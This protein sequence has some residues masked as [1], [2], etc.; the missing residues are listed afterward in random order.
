[1]VSRC[2]RLRSQQS[3]NWFSNVWLGSSFEKCFWAKY[4]R[5]NYN[6]LFCHQ[7]DSCLNSSHAHCH[8]KFDG[9]QSNQ[10]WKNTQTDAVPSTQIKAK[11]SSQVLFSKKRLK[12]SKVIQNI[13]WLWWHRDSCTIS[14]FRSCASSK[15][16]FER[17]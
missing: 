7:F 13:F 9:C 12:V 10:S 5:I 2:N 17:F 16:L 8:K 6:V 11:C 3:C 1:M 15:L 14:T 4:R